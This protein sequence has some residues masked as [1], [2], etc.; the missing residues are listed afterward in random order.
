MVNAQKDID[1]QFPMNQRSQ[2]EG[3]DIS[4]WN[5]EGVLSLTG[6]FS[7]KRL[8]C[9]KNKITVLDLTDCSLLEL[10]N[11]SENPLEEIRGYSPQNWWKLIR[12]VELKYP[13]KLAKGIMKL[14]DVS[15][16]DKIGYNFNL[17]RIQ[18]EDDYFH[19]FL[20][21]YDYSFSSFCSELEKE[22]G[23][24]SIY[25]DCLDNLANR[26]L[27]RCLIKQN[28]LINGID[29]EYEEKI[30]ELVNSCWS[31]EEMDI[32]EGSELDKIQTKVNSELIG[33]SYHIVQMMTN[34]WRKR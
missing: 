25:Y 7:L 24:L 13:H 27:G 33:T 29:V 32:E 21:A 5:L 18:K 9:S 19:L 8:N 23:I 16:L 11:W 1:N 12:D 10:A 22:E 20:P 2:V 6:F 31:E 4:D 30:N 3:L 26:I 34:E 15:D 28:R 14:V 17:Q